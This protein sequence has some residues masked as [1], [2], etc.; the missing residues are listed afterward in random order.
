MLAAQRR[1]LSSGGGL[2]RGRLV[3]ARTAALAR[4]PASPP[5]TGTF[6]L[7][8]T[9]L[10]E[11]EALARTE[12]FAKT[13]QSAI[14]HAQ[15]A[16]DASAPSSA[17]AAALRAEIDALRDPDAAPLGLLLAR[18]DV[19][20]PAPGDL[21]KV[22]IVE[23]DR[24]SRYVKCTRVYPRRLA[25]RVRHDPT[26]DALTSNAA[27]GGAPTVWAYASDAPQADAPPTQQ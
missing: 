3:E 4:P 11:A 25:L 21:I 5:A 7:E 24:G 20:E 8:A 2:V 16:L 1:L 26:A 23:M 18:P 13:K 6:R 17:A 15:A 12:L 10:T 22:R 14:E 19:G 27:L 9:E